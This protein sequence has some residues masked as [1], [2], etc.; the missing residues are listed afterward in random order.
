MKKMMVCFYLHLRETHHSWIIHTSPEVPAHTHTH[1][2]ILIYVGAAVGEEWPVI[3][4]NRSCCKTQWVT[5][6]K[7]GVLSKLKV[8]HF[9]REQS[10]WR[11]RLGEML[12][13]SHA[14]LGMPC[15]PPSPACH[16]STVCRW[17][18]LAGR[19]EGRT[20]CP[21]L[22]PEIIF[23]SFVAALLSSRQ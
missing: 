14:H 1:A 17:N 6:G 20:V 8:W 5:W 18:L 21:V 2:H 22:F 7:A 11:W 16:L 10:F 15:F 3:V 4:W 13:L 9:Q 19:A 23:D 12:A